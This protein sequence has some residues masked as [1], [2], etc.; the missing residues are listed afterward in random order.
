MS[1]SRAT[2][3]TSSLVKRPDSLGEFVQGKE[4]HELVFAFAG[5]LGSG[6]T[7]L[8]GY[9]LEQLEFQG[10]VPCRIKVSEL[11]G[12]QLPPASPLRRALELQTHGDSLRQNH[13]GSIVA[14]LIIRAIKQRRSPA[15]E[16][17]R[18]FIIDSLKNPQEEAIL[19]KIYGDS[20]Y[21]VGVLANEDTR[22]ERLANHKFN[23][24][25]EKDKHKTVTSR[26]GYDQSI[27]SLMDRDASGEKHGQRVKDL[28][29]RSDLFVANE[30]VSKEALSGTFS[31]FI[32]AATESRI[33]RPTRDERGMYAA[34]AASHKSACMSRQVG[35]SI[36][37]AG[38]AILSTGA[39]DPP[40][41]GGGT[42]GPHSA[43]GRDHRCFASGGYC[44][45]DSEKKKIYAEIFE[46][47][48]E[49]SD[50]KSAEDLAVLLESTRIGA[51]IEF[52]RAIHAEMDAL[53]TLVRQGRAILAGTTLYTTTFPCHSCARHIVAAGITEVVYIE[54]Y[55]KSLALEL[56]GDAIES[57]S[58]QTE[59]S[60]PAQKVTF[61]LFTGVAPRR[62]SR[63]FEKKRDL[64][65]DGKYSPIHEPKHISPTLTHGFLD[66]ET[67]IVVQVDTLLGNSN[68]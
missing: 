6:C 12:D 10:F 68:V 33:V 58:V 17:R 37:D 49:H 8:A 60:S 51:L 35:A 11:L 20:F 23:Y 47:I 30:S 46:K 55:T 53:L 59:E 44:R 19:R 41:F 18:A 50:F 65:K 21:L 45:N 5:Y 7:T 62:Q 57:V 43:E 25:D 2:V 31:N 28:L 34:W 52:S 40:Q 26:E 39:N 3:L 29:E 61:R 9:L 67:Y 22:R 13:G 48:R 4:S 66:L 24:A 56:H 27:D 38:G 42:Y 1:G 16:V 15:S 36:V 14:G 63:L 32:M 64:K 54:P